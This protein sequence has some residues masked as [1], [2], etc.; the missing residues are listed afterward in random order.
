MV[1]SDP[2][3]VATGIEHDVPM[4]D[5]RPTPPHDRMIL[6]TPSPTPSEQFA[7]SATRLERLKRLFRRENISK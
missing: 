7:L 2:S 4:A 1:N 5:L 3:L 6:R